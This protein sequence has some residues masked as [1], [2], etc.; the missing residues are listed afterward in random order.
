MEEGQGLKVLMVR[1]FRDA[2]LEKGLAANARSGIRDPELR[3]SSHR[4]DVEALYSTN[5]PRVAFAG[6]SNPVWE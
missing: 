6:S 5:D 3:G 2:L 1:A 4:I